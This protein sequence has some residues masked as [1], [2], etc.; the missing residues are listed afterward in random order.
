MRM[1]LI[2]LLDQSNH[3]EPTGILGTVA[4]LEGTK[5]V[6]D[7][8][9]VVGTGTVVTGDETVDVPGGDVVPL[10]DSGVLLVATIPVVSIFESTVVGIVVSSDVVRIWLTDPNAWTILRITC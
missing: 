4:V 10:V 1:S 8:N 2:I 9:P 3:H 5:V 6:V 7:V